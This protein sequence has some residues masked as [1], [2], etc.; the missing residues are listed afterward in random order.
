MLQNDTKGNLS[1]DCFLPL[2]GLVEIDLRGNR[3]TGTC[4]RE[5]DNFG[6]LLQA[7]YPLAET[8]D[9]M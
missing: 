1:D 8:I 2:S 4:I 9:M 3:I 5:K 6:A 7:A